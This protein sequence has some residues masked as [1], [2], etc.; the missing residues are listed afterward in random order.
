MTKFEEKLDTIALQNICSFVDGNR[1]YVIRE[2]AKLPSHQAVAVAARMTLGMPPALQ[3]DFVHICMT[4]AE[5]DTELVAEIC[6]QATA[7]LEA[8]KYLEAGKCPGCQLIGQ[9]GE[10]CPSCPGFIFDPTP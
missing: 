10:G 9:V 6:D 5:N 2:I 8:G 4:I 3:G 1:S 7:D